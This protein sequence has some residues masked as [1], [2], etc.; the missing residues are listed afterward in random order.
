MTWKRKEWPCLYSYLFC[1]DSEIFIHFYRL[2]NLFM[3]VLTLITVMH[4]VNEPPHYSSA[5]VPIPK[6]ILAWPSSSHSSA[7][8]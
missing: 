8:W 3:T 2:G 4:K 6:S 7:S 1:V 5:Q